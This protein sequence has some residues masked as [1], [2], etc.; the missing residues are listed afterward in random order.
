MKLIVSLVLSMLLA[1]GI[2]TACAGGN[3]PPTSVTQPTGNTEGSTTTNQTNSSQPIMAPV[4]S[5]SL[6][7][8]G[9][10]WSDVPVYPGANEVQFVQGAKPSV[11]T[12]T[13]MEQRVFQIQDNVDKVAAFYKTKLADNGWASQSGSDP[14]IMSTY[15]KDGGKGYLLISIVLD[16][17]QKVTQLVLNKQTK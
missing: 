9:P 13:K 10:Y 15:T 2:L 6:K 8:D 4:G 14:G 12:Y 5:N 11:P 7:G 3:N 17:Q 16:E 1:T